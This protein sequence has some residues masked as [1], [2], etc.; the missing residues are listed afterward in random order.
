MKIYNPPILLL[1]IAMFFLGPLWG[2]PA[3]AN[4]VEAE[5]AKPYYGFVDEHGLLMVTDNPKLI[6]PEYRP[7]VEVLKSRYDRPLALQPGPPPE[8]T[9]A[10][11]PPKKK[12]RQVDFRAIQ[13][14]IGLFVL[15]L[16]L[17]L[18]FMRHNSES[19]ILRAMIKGLML[20]VVMLSFYVLYFSV[21]NERLA[22]V[23]G[24]TKS[25]ETGVDSFKDFI[26]Q[27]Q[28]NTIGEAKRTVEKVKKARA[29]LSDPDLY[30]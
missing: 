18:A 13:L 8:I 3:L 12:T 25:S 28:D 14:G 29:L 1:F 4:S 2:L 20:L 19:L 17:G 16:L 26:E 5:D 7:Q 9:P 21:I 10:F 22:K 24:V 11:P 27:T 15:V 23:A 30:R 6:P